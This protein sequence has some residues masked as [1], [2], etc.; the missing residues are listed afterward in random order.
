MNDIG[1]Y[2]RRQRGRSPPIKITTLRPYLVVSALSAGVS[3][4]CEAKNV[5]LLVQNV[6][7]MHGTDTDIG[8]ELEASFNL[9][10]KRI[11]KSKIW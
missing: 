8:N 5:Q 4:V 11:T 6:E 1:V 7:C 2:L 10:V 9:S 3:N